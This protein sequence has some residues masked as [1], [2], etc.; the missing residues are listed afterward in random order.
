M[1]SAVLIVTFD[2]EEQ[3]EKA[4]KALR[5]WKNEKEIDLGD[6]VVIVKDE[7]G[8]IKVHET[9]EFTTRRGAVSGGVAG[10]VVGTVLGGPIGGLLLGA[11]A[12]A[13]AGKKIDLGVSNDE[14]AAVSES[15]ESCTSAIAV[16]IKSVK[17]KELLAAAI[18]QSGGKIHELSLTDELEMD[19]EEVALRGSIR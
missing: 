4:L 12:G 1:G 10:L 13:L 11:A 6:A 8:K 17:N 5:K 9:S 18:R 14:I 3:G 15:M 2:N 19:L 7:E 16:Q